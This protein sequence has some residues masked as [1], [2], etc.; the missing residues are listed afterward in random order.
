MIPQQLVSLVQDSKRMNKIQI[1]TD[2]IMGKTTADSIG[3]HLSAYLDGRVKIVLH[4]IV[5]FS[6]DGDSLDDIVKLS[7]TFR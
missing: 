1:F 2:Y 3:N 4:D 7:A 6:I 5:N